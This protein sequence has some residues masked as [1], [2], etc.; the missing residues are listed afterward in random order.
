MANEQ[1][2]V[3]TP[4]APAP[5]ATAAPG[6]SATPDVDTTSTLDIADIST[7]LS[8]DPFAEDD[9]VVETA[10][11][12]TPAASAESSDQSVSKE[13]AEATLESDDPAKQDQATETDEVKVPPEVQA[14]LEQNAQL[15]K[16]LEQMQAQQTQQPQEPQQPE[17]PLE[18]LIPPYDYHMPE[19][20]YDLLDSESPDERRT[21]LHAV[22][23]GISQN[24]HRTVLQQVQG[25]M[26]A[27]VPQQLE[28][29]TQQAELRS[30]ISQDFYSTHKDLDKPEIRNIVASV[31]PQVM[32]QLGANA[33]T[34]QVRD[35]IAAQVKALLNYGQAPA[36]QPQPAPQQHAPLMDQGAAPAPSSASSV[37]ND[38]MNT[39][40]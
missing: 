26:T 16:Q 2:T 12:K 18:Q 1:Q 35:A 32:Q 24:V 29:H 7:M 34:P 20:L 9:S 37:Q 40:F 14:I 39:L 10:D 33:W 11:D 28:Q 17:D 30:T 25:M 27:Y 4:A 36:Q 31:T 5:E 15:Q 3:E 21:G 8:F 38:I 23:K 22:M 13:A 19:Q 6:A